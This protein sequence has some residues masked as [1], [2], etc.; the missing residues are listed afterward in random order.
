MNA[1]LNRRDFLKAGGGAL[2]AVALGSTTLHAAELPAA[3]KRTIRKG[4]MYATVELKGTVLEK[5]KAVREAGFEGVEP[6]SHMD[7][8]EVLKALEATGLK[9][10]SV[11]CATHWHQTL[12][13][14]NP[15]TRQRGL[16]GLE[17]ALRDAKRYGAPA[18]LLVAGVVNKQVSYADAYTRSQEQIRKALPLAEELGVKIAI[19]N[20][21]N[22]FL[23]SPLEAA[24]YVDEFNSAWVAWH[25]DVGNV[26]TYGWPE[27]WIRILG[28]RVQTLHIKEYSRKRRD[29][30]GPGKGFEVEFLK[31]DNDWPAVMKAL[32]EIGY[33][34]WGI[35][36]Q[37]GGDS[38]EGLRK[39]SEEM[40]R[41]FA[42]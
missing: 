3:K 19:E 33:Q 31:G 25:F 35:A 30:A 26:I 42:S 14:P 6:M 27:Q 29:E 16:E 23:L 37:P 40:N 28:K 20:V 11:C 36:E 17:Q 7:Q 34:G 21:W 24:R 15:A 4:I 5:F 12:T 2:A 22:Q 1:N 39:L 10:G 8:E 9:A 32:D 18:V 41:I 13:D 38:P